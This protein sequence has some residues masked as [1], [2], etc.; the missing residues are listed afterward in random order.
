MKKVLVADP[1]SQDGIDILKSDSDVE[2]VVKD[3]ISAED[4]LKEIKEYDAIIVRSR[5]KVTREVIAV[6]DRLKAI[7]RGGVGLDNIDQEAAKESNIKVLN[8]PEAS[9]ASVAEHA[10][11]LCFALARHYCR[12]TSTTAAGKWEKKALKGIE[13]GGKT[14]GI[15][16]L[17]RIGRELAKRA[18]GIGMKVIGS[19]PYLDQ[20]ALKGTGIELVG[21]SQVLQESDFI[22]LH[23]PLT[24][25]TKGLI[26]ATELDMMK[27]SAYLVNCSR[28]GI[29]DEDAL[30]KSLS[31][32]KIAGAAIDV[33]ENEPPVDSPLLELS[34]VVLTPHIAASTVDGQKRVSIEVAR[35]V[36]EALE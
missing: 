5:T 33:F 22:S 19:D 20:E 17:G 16:G 6:A 31:E 1:V 30:H 3:T 28:G 13:L 34:N 12:A 24:L 9:S 36:L 4:L 25:E 23:M 26:S 27:S 32:G 11:G 21:L 18:M 2:V 29:V 8:T 14:L 35:K 7:A 10:L 15:V